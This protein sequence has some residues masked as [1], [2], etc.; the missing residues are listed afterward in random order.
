MNFPTS[1]KSFEECEGYFQNKFA[2]IF[3]GENQVIVRI[4]SND[5]KTE[6]KAVYAVQDNKSLKK[7]SDDA[8]MHKGQESN[9]TISIETKKQDKV[10]DPR[11]TQTKPDNHSK[12][13]KKNR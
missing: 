3:H 4:L 12:H 6:D 11:P 9:P 10:I 7:I 13:E 8:E 5:D 2:G 1:F